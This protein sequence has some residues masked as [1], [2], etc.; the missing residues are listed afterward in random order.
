M[1]RKFRTFA[2]GLSPLITIIIPTYNRLE[3]LKTCVAS[4]NNFTFPKDNYEILVVDDGSTDGTSGS[5]K[6]FVASFD[7]RLKFLRQENK[8]PAAARNFGIQHAQGNIIAF[9][10]DDCEPKKEW[11]GEL[12]KGYEDPKVAGTG[13]TILNPNPTNL[14][15]Q[16]CFIQIC[17][18]L[19]LKIVNILQTQIDAYLNKTVLIN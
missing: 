14:V 1:N 17:I 3:Q 7:G 2:M 4:L 16:Y 11:L 18:D 8:G 13:G 15:D 9:I 5:E 6:S 10:D 12:I 19:C